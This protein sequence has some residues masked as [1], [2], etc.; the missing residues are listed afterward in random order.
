MFQ[1]KNINQ[2]QNNDILGKKN[3]NFQNKINKTNN[4]CERKLF[5]ALLHQYRARMSSEQVRKAGLV[6]EWTICLT[7]WL[8]PSDNSCF[9]LALRA[10]QQHNDVVASSGNMT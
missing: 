5:Q 8:W 2:K 4:D 1:S 3:I 7:A 9:R 10:S 6:G